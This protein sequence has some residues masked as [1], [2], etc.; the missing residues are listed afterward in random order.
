MAIPRLR[1]IPG[2]F[3]VTDGVLATGKTRD[4]VKCR[5]RRRAEK[6]LL[7]TT[8]AVILDEVSRHIEY[9]VYTIPD[10]LHPTLDDIKEIV[11]GK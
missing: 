3:T 4:A 10:N 11:N 9:P 5:L 7:K 6:G 1:N 2:A 8:R